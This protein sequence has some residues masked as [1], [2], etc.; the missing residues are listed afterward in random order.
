MSSQRALIIIDYTNDFVADTGA[1]TCG[2]PGQAIDAFIAQ[3][4]QTYLAQDNFVVFATDLHRANDPYH[5][6]SHLFPPHNLLNSWG[7]AWFGATGR[8]ANAHLED[9]HVYAMAKTRY[10]A[11]TGTDL[12][13]WLRARHID[14]LELVGVCTDIC[15][16]H[17]AIGAY[18]LGYQLTIP[19]AGVA[20]FN[21][22]GA[23]WA[24]QH[25]KTTLGA[26]VID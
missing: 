18:D 26:N 22:A 21:P 9:D 15:V 20:T 2:K 17:T 8:F 19:T 7:R 11:F 16:L 5:P 3:R 6:E 10:N 13:L 1:L 14:Q 24:L 23:T 4:A 25:F 12:D